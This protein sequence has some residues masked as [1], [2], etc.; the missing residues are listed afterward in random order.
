MDGYSVS[1]LKVQ[2]T[3]LVRTGSLRVETED[4]DEEGADG[5]IFKVAMSDM[6]ML[7]SKVSEFDMIDSSGTGTSTLHGTDIKAYFSK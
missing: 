1:P 5:V 7:K 4:M 2:L 3:A 6:L